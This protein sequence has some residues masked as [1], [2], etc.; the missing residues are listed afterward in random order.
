MSIK[1]GA[2]LGTAERQAEVPALT[3]NDRV[4]RQTPRHGGR[5]GENW[6]RKLTHLAAQSSWSAT[7]AV[8]G[9]GSSGGEILATIGALRPT[10]R[11]AHDP[12]AALGPGYTFGM[13][14][15]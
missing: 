12:V 9:S 15:A 5:L 4:D 2:D 14:T 11:P 13:K 10:I 8:V 1:H 7:A 6:F 3:R